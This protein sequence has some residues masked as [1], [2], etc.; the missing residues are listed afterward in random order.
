[1]ISPRG[2][3]PQSSSCTANWP[4]ITKTIKIR[5]TR[6]TGHYWRSRDEL[7]NDVILWNPSHGR[8]KARRPARTYIQQFCADTGCS[9]GDLPEAMDDREGR[10]EMVRDIRADGATWWWML[11]LEF[12]TQRLD[13]KLSSSIVFLC[14]F[15]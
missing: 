7:I 1:M 5:R 13:T 8:A 14:V 2:S 11:T 6:H 3:T 12:W 15:V 10:R 9:S 4:P